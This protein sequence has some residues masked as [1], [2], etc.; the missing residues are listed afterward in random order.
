MKDQKGKSCHHTFPLSNSDS[1]EGRESRDTIPS[2]SQSRGKEWET[3]IP[4]T[5]EVQKTLEG[6]R[7]RTHAPISSSASTLAMSHIHLGKGKKKE[8]EVEEGEGEVLEG[9]VLICGH[10]CSAHSTFGC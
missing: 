2:D 9:T 10:F 1:R 7:E 4:S 8:A 3:E 6:G 5:F